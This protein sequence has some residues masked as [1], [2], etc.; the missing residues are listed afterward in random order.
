MEIL[1]EG[2]S[3][4][5]K[6]QVQS[7]LEQ[8][9]YRI[10]YLVRDS[11]HHRQWVCK[12]FPIP[13]EEDLKKE[14][15][16]HFYAEGERQAAI[17]IA[18][19]PRVEEFFAERGYAWTITEHIQG[20]TL[21]VFRS[22]SEGPIAEAQVKAWASTMAEGLRFLHGQDPR[23]V[24]GGFDR[25]EIVVTPAGDVRLRDYGIAR[26]YPP[27][28]R[29]AIPPEGLPRWYD[30][31]M[32]RN[33]KA[34]RQADL[35]S[36]GAL[37]YYALTGVDARHETRKSV[38]SLRPD[39]SESFAAVIEKCLEPFG[40]SVYH[41][42]EEVIDDLSGRRSA[43]RTIPPRLNVDPLR[44]DFPNVS[45][46]AV[47]LERFKV[48]NEG[49]GT[50]SGH[51]HASAPWL[52]VSPQ[53]FEGNQQEVQ[54]WVD[55]SLLHEDTSARAHIVVTSANEEIRV[56]VEVQLHLGKVGGL[57]P[58]L[59]AVL[60]MLVAVLPLA[61]LGWFTV[62]ALRA[63]DLIVQTQG[64]AQVEP[65]SV[66]GLVELRAKAVAL[67]WGR[68]AL[69][70]GVP[71]LVYGAWQSLAAGAR[72]R[73]TLVALATMLLPAL[74]MLGAMRATEGTF[75]ATSVADW[76]RLAPARG[77]GWCLLGT[78][79][80]TMMLMTPGAR[81][82]LFFG[83]SLG[84]RILLAVVLLGGYLWKAASLVAP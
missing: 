19:V 53:H 84:L 59:G 32:L 48:V 6:Y 56:P 13:Q 54:V 28:R 4:A 49:G 35:W 7:L 52:Q 81:Y 16:N 63:A 66:P 80:T 23:M 1:A 67:L 70:I 40:D 43:E 14:F 15:L 78:V 26:I 3:L 9:D 41:A 11:V 72:R 5:G 83:H 61:T 76:L 65:S 62:D 46:G 57:P 42:I 51:V 17:M 34:T 12:Q 31:D 2:A 47:A 8:R 77:G 44:L 20:R 68:F 25:E 74:V 58:R 21:E 36:L 37:C 60:M 75:A 30:S 39:L 50:L 79:V 10:T 18:Q 82:P 64:G 24:L 29:S 27:A 22:E 69:A 71:L 38:S 45:A 73:T 33:A 55:T